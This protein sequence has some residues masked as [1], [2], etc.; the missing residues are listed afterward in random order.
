MTSNNNNKFFIESGE[1]WIGKIPTEWELMPAKR[2]F[3]EIS[4]K[5]RP[6]ETLLSATQDKGVIPRDLLEDRVMMPMGELSGFKFVEKNDFVISLR[7]FQ[8]GIEHSYYRGIVSPA[9]TVLR[10]IHPINKKYFSYLLKSHQ[11]ILELNKAITGIRDGKNISF[12]VFR[13]II[14]PIPPRKEQD[15]IVKFLDDKIADIDRYISSKQKLIALLNEQ[16]SVII[17]Q[18]VTKGIEPAVKMKK[19]GVEWIGEIP[20]GWE[21]RKL[22]Y[23]GRF[24]SGFSFDSELFVDSGVKVLKITNIQTMQ[25]NW[26]DISFIPHKYLEKYKSFIV[27]KGDIIFALTRPVINSGLKAAL[28]DDDEVVLLNQRNAIFRIKDK[29]KREFIYYLIFCDQFEKE[30]SQ[31][32]DFTNQQPNISTNAIGNIKVAI[33]PKEEIK[34]IVNY[35]KEHT[36]HIDNLKLHISKEIALINH[37]KDSLIAE[38]VTGK[39]RIN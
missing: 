3:R 38:A 18:A 14:L 10:V 6:A 19:S 32:I 11:F 31:Q 16:K 26:A 2:I 9:Y 39:L 1:V 20:R 25:L 7:S 13:K 15:A 27:E 17:N 5:N 4:I 37:Y 21:V 24:S 33:P 8:G 28:F 35:L 22:K 36:K 34:I 30:F 12:K 23:I 29:T